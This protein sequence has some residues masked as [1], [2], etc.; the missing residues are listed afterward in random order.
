MNKKLITI[1]LLS[2]IA[3]QIISQNCFAAASLLRTDIKATS[4]IANQNGKSANNITIN[5]ANNMASN[6]GALKKL[7]AL[8][9]LTAKTIG[10]Y[11]KNFYNNKPAFYTALNVAFIATLVTICLKF[12]IITFGNAEKRDGNND[13]ESRDEKNR[14]R[15]RRNSYPSRFL[16]RLIKPTD[17]RQKMQDDK[18]QDDKIQDDKT[19]D[20]K[21]KVTDAQPVPV[22]KEKQEEHAEQPIPASAPPI[23][24]ERAPETNP[25][26]ANE[27]NAFLH[28]SSRTLFVSDE[29]KLDKE[30]IE[31]LIEPAEKI[32]EER[33]KEANTTDEKITQTIKEING[34]ITYTEERIAFLTK[35]EINETKMPL[36]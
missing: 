32:T 35:Q 28:N 25:E 31:R 2:S 12:K 5:Y 27:P 29:N 7:G 13:S 17:K 15:K 1:I 16:P 26:S 20:G 22:A 18:I 19:Q 8:G 6:F 34:K 23:I 11:A 4:A 33:K 30:V 14:K 24:I 21:I 9:T 10:K 36:Y 3:S